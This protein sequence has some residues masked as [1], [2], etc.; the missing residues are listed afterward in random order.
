MLRLLLLVVYDLKDFASIQIGK[1][2]F[3]LFVLQKVNP[4]ILEILTGLEYEHRLYLYSFERRKTKYDFKYYDSYTKVSNLPIIAFTYGV[5][6]TTILIFFNNN[7]IQY[8]SMLFFEPSDLRTFAET[9][10]ALPHPSRT[11]FC[12]TFLS[13]TQPRKQNKVI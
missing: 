5:N 13:I 2:L 12:S 9:L 6:S 4:K 3:W 1:I 10:N 11:R 7:N 8:K